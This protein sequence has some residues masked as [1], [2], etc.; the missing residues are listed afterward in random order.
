MHSVAALTD[1]W[2]PNFTSQHELVSSMSISYA[3]DIS[4]SIDFDLS[5]P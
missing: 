3:G 4:T 1:L 2:A 5:A